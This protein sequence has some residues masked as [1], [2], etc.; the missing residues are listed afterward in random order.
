M[1]I[2]HR[3]VHFTAHAWRGACPALRTFVWRPSKLHARL[4]RSPEG[5]RFCDALHAYTG[6]LFAA[7]PTLVRVERPRLEDVEFPFTEGEPPYV[8]FVR[9][10]EGGD[11][12]E[13]YDVWP[14]RY[15]ND[16]WK[17]A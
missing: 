7:W 4:A 15:D 17:R 11:S 14:W 6:A 8:A 5:G 13:E 10:E 12:D 2:P 3:F 9:T 1:N 16:L